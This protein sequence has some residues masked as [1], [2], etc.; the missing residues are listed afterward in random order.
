MPRPRFDHPRRTVR[1]R[2]RRSAGWALAL[3]IFVAQAAIVPST[4][5]A[6]LDDDGAEPTWSEMAISSIQRPAAVTGGTASAARAD[7]LSAR[8]IHPPPPPPPEVE[9]E[10]PSPFGGPSNSVAATRNWAALARCESG[11]DPTIVSSSG[12]Y[13]G[14]YQFDLPTWRSVGGEGLPSQAPPE[15]QTLRAMAL[16]EKRGSQPWPTCG[17]HL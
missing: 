4:V 13:H 12:R 16:Y 15:E 1:P 7:R 8:E 14:L 6:A 2:S 9:A 10:P 11:G 5:H 3:A 17:R